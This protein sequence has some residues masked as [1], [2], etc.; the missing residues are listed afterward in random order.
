MTKW[1][2]IVYGLLYALLLGWTLI[3]GASTLPM[4]GAT[5]GLMMVFGAYIGMDQ[6]SSF[7]V[8]K[9][10]PVGTKYTGS[11]TKLMLLSVMMVILTAEAM[12]VQYTDK[13]RLLPF[14]QIFL[15]LGVVLSLYAGGNKAVNAAESMGPTKE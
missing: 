5:Y 1:A 15:C 6:W 8:S 14:D 12:W 11:R 2:P 3:P 10:L 9:Q 7:V 4:D 13:S